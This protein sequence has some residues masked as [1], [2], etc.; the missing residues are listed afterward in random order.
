MTIIVV[1]C[2]YINYLNNNKKNI[3]VEKKVFTINNNELLLLND[4]LNSTQYM[5][6]CSKTDNPDWLKQR[7]EFKKIY[8][9]SNDRI[10]NINYGQFLIAGYYDEKAKKIKYEMYFS[11]SRIQVSKNECAEVLCS[12]CLGL[13]K[14][15]SKYAIVGK[16]TNAYLSQKIIR[17]INSGIQRYNEMLILKETRNIKQIN[18]KWKKKIDHIV[19][20]LNIDIRK[21]CPI[22]KIFEP[23]QKNRIYPVIVRKKIK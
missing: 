10:T 14:N 22:T 2:L 1:F 6:K 7:K 15:K 20:K 19:H 4:L 13:K 11:L 18:N 23:I 21:E 3:Y 16:E 8:V 9:I 12:N 5:D 17:Y